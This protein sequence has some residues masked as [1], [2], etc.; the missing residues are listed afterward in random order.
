MAKAQGISMTTLII[1]AI[2]LIV[3]VVLII[4][5]TGNLNKWGI[6]IKSCAARGGKSCSTQPCTPKQTEI[7]NVC[8]TNQ[9]CCVDILD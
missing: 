2:C 1:A 6:D 8:P 4:I 7:P 9:Y 3:L 5:F